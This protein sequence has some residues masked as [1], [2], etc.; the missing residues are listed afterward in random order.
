MQE[1][2]ALLKKLRVLLVDDEEEFIT[3]LAERL[4][5]RGVQTRVLLDGKEALAA[6]EVDT[7]HIVLLDMM[8]PGISGLDVLASI[9]AA[10]PQVH[11]ILLSG[12]AH[13]KDC[14]DIRKKGAFAYLNKPLHL[15]D[16]LKTLYEAGLASGLSS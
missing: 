10:Y 13:A 6:V 8:M 15:D 7:P 12:H 9:K 2:R 3:T 5:L 16:L 4:A 1:I 14:E 11:V